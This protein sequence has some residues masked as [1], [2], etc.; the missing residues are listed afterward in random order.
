MLVDEMLG[1]PPIKYG[2]RLSPVRCTSR[3]LTPNDRTEK[4]DGRYRRIARR[5]D[6][7]IIGDRLAAKCFLFFCHILGLDLHAQTAA[8]RY[9][10]PIFQGNDP[11]CLMVGGGADM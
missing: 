1:L 11:E 4:P 6:R 8:H 5:T 9:V 3:K 7:L 2:F 10:D